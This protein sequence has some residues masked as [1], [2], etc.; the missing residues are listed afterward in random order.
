M[1]VWSILDFLVLDGK[2]GP[3]TCRLTNTTAKLAGNRNV[4]VVEHYK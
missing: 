3:L 2:L 4:F 1:D